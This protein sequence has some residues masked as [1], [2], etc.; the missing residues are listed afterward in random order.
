MNILL[1]IVLFGIL[2]FIHE[3]GHFAVAKLSGVFVE[4]FALGFGPT[5]ARKKWGETEYALCLLPLGG[6]VK[7]R[8]EEMEENDLKGA[9]DPRSFASQTVGKRFAIVAMGP[10][11]N[12]I[13]PVLLFT[14][15][16]WVG[17][18]VPLPQVGAVIPD[19]PA[20]KAGLRA[21]D[22]IVRVGEASVS[23]WNELMAALR[24]R[25]N[26]STELRI[27]R[28][29]H[30]ITK[31]IVPVSE[32]ELNL[33][34]ETQAAGKIGI[35]LQPYRPT[36]GIPDANS[37]A[38][39]VG[40]KTGD[41]VLSVNGQPMSYWW[42]MEARFSTH[43]PKKLVVERRVA[44]DAVPTQISLELDAPTLSAAGIEDGELYIR[45]VQPDS[46]AAQK[47]LKAG[48]RL[49][50]VNRTP[51]S[52]WYSFRKQIQENRGDAVSVEILRSGKRL[53]LEL[54]PREVEHKDEFTKESRKVRQLGVISC[55]MPGDP[56]TRIERYL[57]PFRALARGAEETWEISRTTVIGISKLITGKLGL[58]SLGGPI[59]IFYLA[60]SSYRVGGWISYFRMMAILSI[61]LAIL[62]FLPIPILDGG[63]LFFFLIE[64]VK[65]GPVGARVR[66][67]A[68]QVGL[69]II[70][71][72][73]ILTFYVDINRYIVDKIRALF[74]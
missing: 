21:G 74:N 28:N 68:Q 63:H 34:G 62:N 35:E 30:E 33:Y 48:D 32:N 57:N 26:L 1:P 70:V 22:Q 39:R 50:S 5:I 56:G 55:A 37:P 31:E 16:F 72:L 29:G 69:F 9:P 27:V 2:V 41:T 45:D 14:G 17:T 10:I 65:G 60:G 11:S 54:I 52:G 7:M 3:L 59:S 12:L 40:F 8:G 23:T 15:L 53:T 71:G 64:I 6:Y 47:G 58:N 36:I 43:G 67:V 25:A 44:L 38:A 66:Q 51:L 49:L 13:L 4:R 46:I 18:P 61:T 24:P 20:A 19:Y 42:Q 73:M